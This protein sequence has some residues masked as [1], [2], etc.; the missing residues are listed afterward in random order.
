MTLNIYTWDIS[1]EAQDRGIKKGICTLTYDKFTLQENDNE[2]IST[3]SF[4]SW[5][6]I[7]VETYG[8]AIIC[9]AE[10][11]NV[12]FI[13]NSI[14]HF[15]IYKRDLEKLNEF[16]NK[17]NY[18]MSIIQKSVYS[19]IDTE[20]LDMAENLLNI[21]EENIMLN[22]RIVARCHINYSH[23]ESKI[24]TRNGIID[25]YSFYYD[26][27]KDTRK[28]KGKAKK[29]AEIFNNELHKKIN[30]FSKLIDNFADIITEEKKNN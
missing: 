28:L 2:R 21:A 30:E 20:I 5:D 1:K 11:Y 6:I 26:L 15:F 14:R 29:D 24:F 25:K 23:I 3:Y 27:S 10:F 4:P 17:R 9:N 19:Y 16:C 12:S 13:S 8:G 18:E 22:Y 7:Q